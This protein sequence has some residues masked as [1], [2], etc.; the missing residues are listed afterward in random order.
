MEVLEKLA[1]LFVTRDQSVD[2]RYKEQWAARAKAIAADPLG[3]RAP[4]VGKLSR[5]ISRREESRSQGILQQSE[6]PQ[7]ANYIVYI[8]AK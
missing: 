4:L 3:A 1:I 5:I 7:L 8:E 6:R 2:D